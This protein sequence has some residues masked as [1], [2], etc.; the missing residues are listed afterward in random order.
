MRFIVL[1]EYFFPE[2]GAAQTRL[3]ALTAALRKSGHHVE[4]VTAFPHYPSPPSPI[5]RLYKLEHHDSTPVH[6]T[7]IY[8]SSGTGMR[9][10]LGYFSF[11]LTGLLG[12]AKCHRPDALIVESPPLFLFL[13]GWLYARLRGC[14]CILNVADLWP[15]AAVEFGV[16]R[17][18]T[19]IGL[20]RLLERWA[21]SH[22]TLLNATTS[23]IMRHLI[24]DNQVPPSKVLFLPNGVDVELFKPIPPDSQLQRTL[25]PEG[26][27]LILYAGTHGIAHGMQVILEA[28]VC[29]R[30]EPFLFVLVGGGTDKPRLR[31]LAL[32]LG[33]NNVVFL[34]P[35]PAYALP[36]FYSVADIALVTV[37]NSKMAES[38][39]P[40]KMLSAMA[41]GVPVIFVGRGEGADLVQTANAGI[42]TEPDEPEAL[43]KAI[44]QL[45]THPEQRRLFGNNGRM[46]VM[47]HFQWEKILERWLCDLEHR[48]SR[49]AESTVTNG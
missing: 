15:D 22:A 28:A 7:W 18:R 19:L 37:R 26:K 2:I 39:R 45:A 49:H 24:H 30:Q 5:R 44:R 20:G 32:N 34:D 35:V 27:I 40:V 41:S 29:V 21:Y 1:T 17:S 33:L 38:I 47:Q 48:L 36:K 9:R 43:A 12:L 16:L 25:N 42:I 23:G 3:S 6:R 46:F 11:T 8:A 31:S 10:L 4:V 13:T 14:P